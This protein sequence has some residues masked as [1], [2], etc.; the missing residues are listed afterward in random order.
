MGTTKTVHSAVEANVARADNGKLL[1]KVPLNPPFTRAQLK[2]A[3]PEHCFQRSHLRS[4]TYLAANLMLVWLCYRTIPLFE[5]SPVAWLV[6]PIYW[7]VQGALCTGLWV[8]A[9]E[10]G[11][12]AFSPHDAVND[13]VGLVLHSALLVPYHSWRIS[14]REHHAYTNHTERDQV[15]NPLKA[16]D[17][18]DLDLFA[19]G[20]FL[21]TS[22]GR[23]CSMIVTLTLGW[24]AYL[25]FNITGRDYGKPGTNHF[26]PN[27]PI[28]AEKER[29]LI[30]LS[31]AALVVVLGLLGVWAYNTSVATVI[32]SYGLPYLW[33]NFWLVL[34]TLLQHTDYAIPHYDSR[35]WD[36]V[37]GALCTVDR[38]Y[39]LLNHVFHHIGDTHV[40]HHLFH[41]IPHYHAQEATRALIPLLGDYY[42]RDSTP[43]MEALGQAFYNCTCLTPAKEEQG[44]FWWHSLTDIRSRLSKKDN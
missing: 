13:A 24:P 1:E 42:R 16:G 40:V 29:S 20:F 41:T 11:H 8:I 25:F 33:V 19:D 18:G 5:A 35:K 17:L 38:D 2:S 14:H 28:F 36:W 22:F 27:S 6:W 23:I 15:F 44:T 7:F 39:G 10:C 26:N 34:I 21:R 12:R 30:L 9:H 3:I 4:F 32:F 31:D 37:K 43:I